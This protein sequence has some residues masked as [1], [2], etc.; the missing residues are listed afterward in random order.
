MKVDILPAKPPGCV[1]RVTNAFDHANGRTVMAV[2]VP[3]SVRA[4]LDEQ[5]VAEFDRPTVCIYNGQALM[6]ADWSV[7]TI[8]PGDVVVFVTLPHGGGGGGGGGKSPL[9]TV[10]SIAIMV[11]GMAVGAALGPAL[12]FNLGIP[13][14]GIGPFGSA[15][16]GKGLISGAFMLA[17]NV[18]MSSLL[19]SP[20]S[21]APAQS[22]GSYGS[23]PAPSP[24]Y[25]LT[26][27]GNQARLGQPIP[28]VYGRHKW[29]PDLASEPYQEYVGN[30]QFLYQLHVLG[31]GEYDVEKIMIEDTPISSFA[32]VEYEIIP[33]GGTLTLVDPDVVTAPEVAGQELKG[34]N[35]LGSGES[36]YVG[37]FVVCDSDRKVDKIG[38]DI[39]F[40]RGLYYANASG[41]LDS[42]TVQWRVEARVIDEEGDPVGDGSYT[43]LATESLTDATNTAIRKSYSYTVTEGRYDVRAIRLDDKD[44]D[45]RAGHE[46]RWAELRGYLTGEIDFG[47]ITLLAVKMRATDNLSQRSSRMINVIATRKLPIW[48]PTTQT[49]SAPV[50][51]RSIM[52]AFADACRA[53]YGGELADSRLPLADYVAM[54]AK[55][56]ARGNHFDAVFDSQMTLWEALIRIARCGRSV[57]V[58]QGGRVRI[59]RDEPQSVPVAMFNGRNIVRGSFKIKYVLPS[60]ETADAV[61]VQYFSSKTW[62]PAE[63]TAR[64]RDAAYFAWLTA[65]SLTDTDA[66]MQD[67]AALAEKP[68]TVQ[69]FGVTDKQHALE[70]A[71]FMAADNRYRRVLPTIRTEMDGMIPTYG[72]LI[73]VSHDMPQWGQ[74][75]ELTGWTADNIEAGAPYA[76]AVLT[77][78]EPP[79]WTE[80]QTHYIALRKRDG[81]M[82]GPFEVAAGDAANKV[83]LVDALT[84][85]PYVG[86]EEERT[87]YSFGP[88]DEWGK[89][90]LVKS[91]KPRNGGE[92][93][94]IGAVVEDSRVHVN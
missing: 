45:A 13:V 28:V 42:K 3:M 86:S 26:A 24:T 17:G 29:P 77:L 84:I 87:Y 47:N 31:Q 7:A 76:N 58:Q 20:K 64:V 32:E 83:A 75:G 48:N 21:A 16:I 63:V 79:S 66:N 65:N 18:L 46:V 36:G 4:W 78:S 74:G 6:R 82:V 37:P 23:T 5:G 35:Q 19:P 30:E 14:T 69:L 51:T 94:E 1:V 2:D 60:D 93:V 88:G 57:P 72:D 25:S 41:G 15:M 38:I 27:Q 81:S 62:K 22:W 73:L 53:E 90:C 50:A 49:W 9:K 10:L 54:D 89:P 59:F 33:P 44:M 55:L 92:Q 91:L 40:P 11:A 52:W 12:A 70:E 8:C 56:E 80:G 39:V 43:T 85:T 71:E 67:W 34:P 61:T 68:A